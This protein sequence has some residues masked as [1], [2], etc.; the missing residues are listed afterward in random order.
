MRMRKTYE[1]AV[2]ECLVRFPSAFPSVRLYT[3]SEF[4]PTTP[5]TVLHVEM[6]FIRTSQFRGSGVNIEPYELV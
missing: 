2:S 5:V 1:I 3:N 6:I 4:H